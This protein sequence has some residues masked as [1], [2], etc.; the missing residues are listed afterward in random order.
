MLVDCAAWH[1]APRLASRFP[2]EAAVIHY[3][4]IVANALQL[5]SSGEHRVPTFDPTAWDAIDLSP[6]VLPGLFKQLEFQFGHAV[7][8]I[9]GPEH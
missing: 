6:T 2:A 9:L 4:D 7:N 8:A 5:G 3:A 1:H